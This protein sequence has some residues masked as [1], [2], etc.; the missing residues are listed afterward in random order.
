MLK[1]AAAILSHAEEYETEIVAKRPGFAAPFFATVK[2]RIDDALLNIIGMRTAESLV[3]S[4]I[5]MLQI[6][7]NAL[8]DLSFFFTNLE[9][10]YKDNKD[11]LRIR[12]A[13]LGFEEHYTQ[14]FMKQSPLIQLLFKFKLNMS[15]TLKA[16]IESKGMDLTLIP[17]IISYADA[18]NTAEDVQESL[19]GGR[20]VLTADKLAELNAIYGQAITVA[21]ISNKIFK[22]DPAR[23]QLFNFSK[24]YRNL[25]A[26]A[27]AEETEETPEPTVP[28]PTV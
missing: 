18:L 17:R 13:T 5:A 27:P 21:R 8:N 10:D 2:T 23:K 3:Q 9:E 19:K 1:V 22:N 15:A 11:L 16:E 25:R 28:T 4:T 12:L 14:A 24:T 7:Q 20:P 6:R 26:P